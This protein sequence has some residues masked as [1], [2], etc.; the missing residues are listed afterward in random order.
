MT[1]RLAAALLLTGTL[2]GCHN[3]FRPA[4]PA[5]APAA[6]EP[7]LPVKKIEEEIV[8]AAWAEPRRL[9]EGGGQAHILVR[10]QKR[11]G[12][13]FPG[14]EVRLSA[15]TGSLYSNGQILLTDARGMTRDRLSTRKT[16]AIVLNAGGT[17][18]RFIVPTGDA[19]ATK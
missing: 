17:R 1:R 18:Y 8:V 11:G 5:D 15:S 3:L 10:V 6:E 19:T 9:P 13:P 12:A 2:A 16:S 7:P 4:P 14:V